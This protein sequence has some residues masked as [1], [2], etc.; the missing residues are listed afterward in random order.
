MKSHV[1]FRYVIGET[2]FDNSS[3]PFLLVLCEESD[4]RII[5][6]TLLDQAGGIAGHLPIGQGDL[7]RLPEDILVAILGS[8]A[9][10]TRPKPAINLRRF[11]LVGNTVS[12]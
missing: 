5:L 12:E 8:W 11:D 9:P 3:Q 6:G 1:E 10:L 4:A 2:L 7:V